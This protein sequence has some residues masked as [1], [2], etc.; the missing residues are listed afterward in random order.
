MKLTSIDSG[1]DFDF[2]KTSADYAV[3]RDIYPNSMYD[4]LI[5][6]GIGKQELLLFQRIFPKIRSLSA[7]SL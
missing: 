1:N 4:K 5:A 7:D 6:F 2:G 3:F